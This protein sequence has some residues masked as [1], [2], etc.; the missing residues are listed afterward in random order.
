M[1]A[2]L[3]LLRSDQAVMGFVAYGDSNSTNR[4]DACPLLEQVTR[5]TREHHHEVERAIFDEIV[6]M[7][8]DWTMPVF[9][10]W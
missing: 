6:W 2:V 3:G 4:V 9:C 1:L 10:L 8:M 7:K 5:P